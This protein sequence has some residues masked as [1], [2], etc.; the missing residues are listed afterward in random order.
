ML[1]SALCGFL[2]ICTGVFLLQ[3]SKESDNTSESELRRSPLQEAIEMTVRVIYI[4]AIYRYAERKRERE[5]EFLY[6]YFL[7]SP[8]KSLDNVDTDRLLGR[9]ERPID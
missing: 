3:I 1:V 8:F 9:P 4:G 5:I 2:T 6:S 7:F